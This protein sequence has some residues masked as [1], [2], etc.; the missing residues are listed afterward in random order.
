MN[1]IL[2]NQHYTVEW[3]YNNDLL[4]AYHTVNTNIV[5]C[6]KGHSPSLILRVQMARAFCGFAREGELAGTLPPVRL[7]APGPEDAD[8]Q[9]IHRV[10]R[11]EVAMTVRGILRE[12]AKN[13][14]AKMA[15]KDDPTTG[16]ISETGWRYTM[17]GKSGTAKIPLGKPPTGM[18][19]P[20]GLRGYYEHQYNASF[21][22]SGPTELPRLVVLVVID[23]PGPR[24]VRENRYYG[25]QTAGPVVRRVLERSLGYL[26]VR[27]S[28]VEL[29]GA[30][31]PT[32]PAAD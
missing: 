16:H 15:A 25:S 10:L 9:V 20:P 21:V 26:G 22:G 17:F 12:V 32:R 8:G 13:T 30:A 28:P 29:T 1:K 27:P 11:G 19:P 2:V 23:D 14:E 3:C 4:R 6:P 7:T 18:A 5:L 24:L 31:D